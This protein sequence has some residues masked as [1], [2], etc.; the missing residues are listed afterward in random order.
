MI[1]GR[2][3]DFM[4]VRKIAAAISALLVVVSIISLTIN[5]LEFGLDFTSGTS[6]RLNYGGTVD[7]DEVNGILQ[8]NGYEDAVVVSFGTDRDI[9]IILPVDETVDVQD[10]A[11]QAVEV[12]A[13]IAALL[14]SN[15]DAQISL[16]GSDYVSAKVGE[17]LAEQGGLGMLV[18]LGI[19]MVYIA[20]RFQFKFSVGAVVALA[21]DL[22]VT[23]GIFSLVRMEFNLNTLAAMLAIIG[24]SLNDTIV[25]S[26]RIRE[27]FR[28]MR[29]GTPIEMV[30]KSLN[31]TLS[32]TLI[33]SFTTLLVLFSILIIGGESTQGFAVALI[34]GVIIGTYS[35]VYIAS[36][37]IIYMKVTREDLMIPLKEGADL[38]GHP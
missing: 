34:I 11:G 19:I 25:V 32:R 9:R 14:R 3:I 38:E 13:T 31:Q 36:N 23:L 5:S 24:Y 6:V 1:L 15:S 4:G 18:A 28:R 8:N 2:E 7:L 30:N 35:S 37:V 33:T 17:E 26:D 20:V 10:Q 29:R 16:L 12:G 27:N 22:I 21:H